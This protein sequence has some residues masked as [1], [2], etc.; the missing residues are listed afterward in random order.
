MDGWTDQMFHLVGKTACT[1]IIEVFSLRDL[2]L[3][4]KLV[5]ASPGKNCERS[6]RRDASRMASEREFT[7]ANEKWIKKEKTWRKNIRRKSERSRRK[8]INSFRLCFIPTSLHVWYSITCLPQQEDEPT[9]AA[10]ASSPSCDHIAI[11]SIG[12]PIIGS[13]EN[14]ILRWY[15]KLCIFLLF[16]PFI[17]SLS[18]RGDFFAIFHRKSA[19]STDFFSVYTFCK[20]K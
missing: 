16:F 8:K 12:I 18:L 1:N 2:F 14:T 19:L 6:S 9:H 7:C 17:F 20:Y 3:A 11:V 5:V 10:K 15:V 4:P 13:S